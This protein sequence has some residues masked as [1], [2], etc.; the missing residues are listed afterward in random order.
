MNLEKLFDKQRLLD[1]RIRREKGLEGQDTLSKKILSLQ[2]EVGECAN[3]WRG[4][5][6]WSNDQ[7]P[8]LK[9]I[10]TINEDRVYYNPLL[11]EYI[12]GLHFVLSIGLEL[13]YVLKETGMSKVVVDFKGNEISTQFRL[14]YNCISNLDFSNKSLK[15]AYYKQLV[16]HYIGLG[17]MLGFTAAEIEQAYM[18]KNK[19]N[20]QRQSN[21]Y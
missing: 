19:I 20:H 21:G 3:E 15:R 12:D 1:D 5:K 17:V 11:E 10:R 2:V 13:N 4:F 8:R 9:K 14:I 6:F 16:S 7:N 18:D